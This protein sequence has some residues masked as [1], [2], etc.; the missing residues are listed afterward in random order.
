MRAGEILAVRQ[1]N[2]SLSGHP[3]LRNIDFALE[4]GEFCGLIGSNGSGKT[5]LLRTILGFVP[6]QS[7]VTIGGGGRRLASVGYVS[8]KSMLDPYIPIR[9]RDLV[10]LGLDGLDCPLFR[11]GLSGSSSP[12]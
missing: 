1:A 12:V 3:I 5:T 10:A 2:V 9:A 6:L 7:S 8:Q 11:L 4:P